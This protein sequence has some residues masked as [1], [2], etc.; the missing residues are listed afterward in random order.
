[1]DKNDIKILLVDDDEEGLKTRAKL[2]RTMGYKCV[3]A[4]D[5]VEALSMIEDERPGIIMSDQVMPRMDGMNLLQEAK[6]IDPEIIV[7]IYTGHGSVHNAVRAIRIGAFDYIPKP[8]TSEQ[9]KI[10]LDRAIK[11]AGLAR[12]N[13]NLRTQ[14]IET[15][16][17]KGAI[18]TSPAMKEV[19]KKIVKVAPTNA[20][21]LISGE[22]GSGKEVIAKSIHYYS[23][24]SDQ[25]FVAVDPVAL[26]EG[27]L[28]SEL[29]GYEK[30]SFTSA[31][32]SKAGLLE[33]ASG[34]TLFLDEIGE[35]SVAT[36][37]KF[38]RVIQEREFRRI[39]GRETISIDIRLISATQRDPE[40]AVKEGT[41]REELYFRLNVIHLTL[42]PLRERKED[43][44]LL[45][46]HFLRQFCKN[47][48]VQVSQISDDVLMLLQQFNWPGNVRQLQS[49]IEH[50]VTLATGPVIGP[51]VL[52]EY[53]RPK[54]KV[55][56]PNI[57]SDLNF[58]EAKDRLVHNFE[59]QYLE[60]LIKKHKG[61]IA[62]AAKEAGLNRKTIYRL[63]SAH[64]IKHKNINYN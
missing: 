32:Q 26:P 57:A 39:G 40:Q 3:T 13:A 1:M 47:S 58:K 41:L 34:G 12:E 24:R 42:P 35:I 62:R 2:L 48:D 7:I 9:M 60:N 43:I 45:A 55:I 4:S 59:K 17:F 10:V 23:K 53:I 33:M 37:A 49:T 5:G 21:V 64:G 44:P 50:A 46:Y 51:D 63:L 38:L 8:F 18:G 30:G 54:E 20:N 11:H 56:I 28:E 31:H 19:F 16:D 14:L 29:F 25:P 22:T 61:V 27:V 36:Q 6:K 15:Y 52:P